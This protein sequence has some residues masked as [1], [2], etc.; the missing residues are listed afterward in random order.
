M[1]W[2]NTLFL[3]HSFC[4][5]GQTFSV[6][7]LLNYSQGQ[8]Q[9]LSQDAEFL[10]GGSGEDFS[11]PLSWVVGWIQFLV[12]RLKFLFPCWLSA[13][14]CFQ[15]VDVTCIFF[16]MLPPFSSQQRHGMDPSCTLNPSD[17]IFCQQWENFLLKRDL[18]V[19]LLD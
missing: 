19:M 13:R 10:S 16:H 11:F 17:L 14:I 5:W 6:G 8:S 12:L 2:N 18:S 15:F 9:M 7:S 3:S 4:Q 1:A